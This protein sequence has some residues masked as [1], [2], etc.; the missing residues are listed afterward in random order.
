MYRLVIIDRTDPK[1]KFFQKMDGPDTQPF[2][3]L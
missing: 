1:A 2:F 3:Y